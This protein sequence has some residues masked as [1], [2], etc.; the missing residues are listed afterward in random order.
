[1]ARRRACP[2]EA[3]RVRA[4]RRD[5]ARSERGKAYKRGRTFTDNHA[6]RQRLTGAPFAW[7]P[8]AWAACL[9]RWGRACVYCDAPDDLTQDHFVPVSAPD[10]PGTIPANMV[11][12]C[13]RCN[14]AK[15]KRSPFV[16]VTDAE[17]L[18]RIVEGLAAL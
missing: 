11:P 12:A 18:R 14:R 6:R 4:S 2:V 9:E 5:H 15:G 17:R 13:G 1:M 10:Y 8:E 7:G 3:A 16:W